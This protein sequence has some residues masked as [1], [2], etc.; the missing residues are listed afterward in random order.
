MYT[1]LIKDIFKETTFIQV[2]FLKETYLTFNPSML[3]LINKRITMS[4]T[5]IPSLVTLVEHGEFLGFH[6]NNEV[7]IIDNKSYI[8]ITDGINHDVCNFNSITWKTVE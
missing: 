1:N 6:D 4:I 7:Y 5:I 8:I 3:Y 2:C